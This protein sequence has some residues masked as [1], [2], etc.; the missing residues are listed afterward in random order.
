M[1]LHIEDLL[2][3]YNCITS[4]INSAAVTHAP[5][6]KVQMSVDTAGAIL[7]KIKEEAQESSEDREDFTDVNSAGEASKSYG[8]VNRDLFVKGMTD[9]QKR[10]GNY[11]LDKLDKSKHNEQLLMLL[12]GPPGTGKSFLI[13]RLRKMTDVIMRITATSGVAAMSLNGTTI[14]HFLAR[15]YRKKNKSKLETVRTNLGDATLLVVD[16]LSMMG[17][18]KLVEMDATLQ[19]L[20]KTSA[21]F[22]G[23]DVI[24]VGDFAQ[25][26]P[27]KQTSL[28]EAMVSSTLL[29]TPPT[30]CTLKTTALM[31]RF[32]KYDLEEFNRSKSCT[33]LSSLLRQ[34]RNCFSGNDSFTV[35]DIKRIGVLDNGIFAKDTK[36]RNA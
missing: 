17:C 31:S 15:G 25:L 13:K 33:R 22:G 3:Q 32:V 34:F 2:A 16:E 28:I 36:F 27:V 29:H 5:R 10:A 23:L 4:G 18:K 35:E 1:E 26:P 30:E 21:P 8:F 24:L 14:D 19:K 11:M 6:K 20:K 12:H 9:D 7:S